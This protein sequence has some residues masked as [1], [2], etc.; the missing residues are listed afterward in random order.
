MKQEYLA[1]LDSSADRYGVPRDVARNLIG[2]ESAWNPSAVS[3]AGAMGLGQLMPATAAELGVDP[4][5]PFQNM[6]GSMRYLGKQINKYGL[7]GGLAAYNG[8]P[9]RWEK[10]GGNL[11]LMPAE[12]QKYVPA[13]LGGNMANVVDATATM[14][15]MG[16]LPRS[17]AAYFSPGDANF[18]AQN[19][20]KIN[21]EVA[22]ELA[23]IREQKMA[24]LPLA[25]A[26]SMSSNQGS[27]NFGQL[28]TALA[29]PAMD[30]TAM[31]NGRITPDGQYITD[32]SDADQWKAYAAMMAADNKG[33]QL[34]ANG[35]T[36]RLPGNTS[37]FGY[38]PEGE[39]IVTNQGAPYKVT[40][41]PRGPVYTPY[42]GTTIDDATYEKNVEGAKGQ[43]T[44]AS[45]LGKHETTAKTNPGGFGFTAAAVSK[46]PGALKSWVGDAY[47]TPEERKARAGIFEQATQQI[48]DLAGASQTP[49][50]ASRIERF[51]PSDWDSAETIQQKLASARAIAQGKFDDNA[52]GIKRAAQARVSTQVSNAPNVGNQST[53]GQERKQDNGVWYVKRNGQWFAE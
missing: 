16:A 20:N 15:A 43:L 41:T 45:E 14:Q 5:D 51:M 2:R 3:H 29:M 11:G 48:H 35:N 13:I 47:F 24:M 19:V 34:D 27:Q 12:T 17:Q 52:S 39:K 40:M 30:G 25:L 4:R 49:Q 22:A 50:E 9:G 6:E 33:P 28:L 21:P 46:L 1:Y 8:G 37:N 32:Q 18:K 7:V 26:H 38:S 42:E 31:K 53:Q 10:S 23:Q 36:T 44:R